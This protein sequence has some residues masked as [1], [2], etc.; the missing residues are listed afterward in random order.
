M[1][2]ALLPPAELVEK[3][4]EH[5]ANAGGDNGIQQQLESE[6]RHVMGEQHALGDGEHYL[7]KM[8][9]DED[10]AEAADGMLRINSRAHGRGH[11]ADARFCYAVHADWIVVAQCILRDADGRA[12]EHSA[13]RVAAADAEINRDEQG[14]IDEFREAAVFMKKGL[15]HKSKETDERN[16]AAI[17]FVYFNIG[18]RTRAGA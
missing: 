9:K 13:D 15:Q 8:K 14:K 2:N 16:R 17:V 5:H 11:I 4:E 1:E 3:S 7:M 6:H 10:E 18:F 12:E